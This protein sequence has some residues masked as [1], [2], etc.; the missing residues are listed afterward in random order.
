MGMQG[1]QPRPMMPMMNAPSGMPPGMMGEHPL[2]APSPHN[3]NRKPVLGMGMRPPGMMGPPPGYPA[4]MG[5]GMYP[6]PMMAGPPGQHMQSPWGGGQNADQQQQQ[7]QQQ[8]GGSGGSQPMSIQQQLQQ[9]SLA[10]QQQQVVCMSIMFFS[11]LQPHH[12]PFAL[13]QN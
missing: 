3:L 11:H 9:Q 5:M 2:R 12:S 8:Q 13:K 7:Q 10:Q 1:H 6:P 4:G